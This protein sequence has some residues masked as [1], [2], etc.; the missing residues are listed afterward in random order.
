MSEL[1]NDYSSVYEEGCDAFQSY[2]P[3]LKKW[4]QIG[5]R[6]FYDPTL[7]KALLCLGDVEGSSMSKMLSSEREMNF[8][9]KGKYGAAIKYNEFVIKTNVRRITS[10]GGVEETREDIINDF[11]VGNELNK[12]NLMNMTRTLGYFEGEGVDLDEFTDDIYFTEEYNGV[13][14]L[15]ER[16]YG[17]T[18]KTKI[19]EWAKQKEIHNFIVCYLQIVFT[20][21]I[22]NKEKG[23]IHADLHDDNIL[24]MQLEKPVLI[25]YF[26]PNGETVVLLTP[27]IVKIIDFGM[28]VISL[29]TPKGRK[30]R[31]HNPL[32][33]YP[34]SQT[35]S[36]FF[37][38]NKILGFTIT[39]FHRENAS[40]VSSV[41]VL[42]D[43][44]YP[45][46]PLYRKEDRKFEYN[47]KRYNPG[48]E[49][50]NK[51]R[52]FINYSGSK[53]D[54]QK[55][56]FAL[57]EAEEMEV[58]QTLSMDDYYDY[59]KYLL[60]TYY[61]AKYIYYKPS[62]LEKLP[63]QYKKS[64]WAVCDKPTLQRLVR[65]GWKGQSL[66][67]TPSELKNKVE[68]TYY[69]VHVMYFFAKDVLKFKERERFHTMYPDAKKI[70]QRGLKSTTTKYHAEELRRKYF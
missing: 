57:T 65:E 13:Y 58:R 56:Y 53:G 46:T 42:A 29:T 31:I 40:M 61:K 14:I 3:D 60:H 30:K 66:C 10:K 54:S 26:L 23:F 24:V 1:L 49:Q 34:A 68:Y 39:N 9:A 4:H 12:L 28:S 45:L 67:L 8:L 64:L 51:D 18:L 11:L 16:V 6:Y 52:R 43:Y 37:D 33:D 47:Y 38:L 22:A 70:I 50:Y 62:D 48:D 55:A 44:I 36:P 35:V 7:H 32:W 25:P 69:D 17:E 27:Y 19:R 20:I 63:S 21:W 59:L 41:A 5:K 2:R 15:Q